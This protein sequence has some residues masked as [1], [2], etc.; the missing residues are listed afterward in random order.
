MCGIAGFVNQHDDRDGRDALEI[1][2]R[3]SRVIEHRGPDDQGLL[4]KG[5]AALGM[6]T[7]F[8]AAKLE[9]A[10]SIAC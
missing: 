8:P 10:S 9:A 6:R 7:D 1:L 2:D 3:M 4:V 5:P